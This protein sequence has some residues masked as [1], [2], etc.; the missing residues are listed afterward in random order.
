MT[1]CRSQLAGE[2]GV[3][4]DRVREQAHFYLTL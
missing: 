3:R 4:E 1:G 2:S